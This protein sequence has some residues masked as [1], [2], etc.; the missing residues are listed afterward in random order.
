MSDSDSLLEKNYV[1]VGSVFDCSVRSIALSSTRHL[2]AY[3]LKYLDFVK[4]S[5]N[6]NEILLQTMKSLVVI[7]L[8]DLVL[9]YNY[10]LRGE[11][12]RV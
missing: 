8:R 10:K 7:K 1:E 2:N 5:Q 9:T 12:D 3:R 4:F 11:Q 6:G